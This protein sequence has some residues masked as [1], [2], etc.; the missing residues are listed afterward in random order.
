MRPSR[1]QFR[2]LFWESDWVAIRKGCA[3]VV[4]TERR[5]QPPTNRKAPRSGWCTSQRPCSQYV[6]WD[7]RHRAVCLQFQWMLA[8]RRSLLVGDPRAIPRGWFAHRIPAEFTDYEDARIHDLQ[9]G[10]ASRA[11]AVGESLP[12]T[13]LYHSQ[14]RDRGNSPFSTANRKTSSSAE[15][16]F[17]SVLR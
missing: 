17:S 14:N 12:M 7:S 11:L 2:E 3:D 1:N 4:G 6:V 8:L 9:H 5:I 16:N 10:Y 15:K 13:A